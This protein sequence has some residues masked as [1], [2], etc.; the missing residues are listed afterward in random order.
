M[1]VGADY[2]VSQNLTIGAAL[3]YANTEADLNYDG[4]VRSNNGYASVY[5]TYHRRGFYVDGVATAGI[6]SVDTH[7]QTIGGLTRGETETRSFAT[8]LGIGY[9]CQIGN[10]SIGPVASLRYARTSLDS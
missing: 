7:R 2:L 5:A 1:T 9:D 3:G 6:G 10:F 4:Y 8:L